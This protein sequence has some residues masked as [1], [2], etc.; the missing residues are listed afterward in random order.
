MDSVIFICLNFVLGTA[1]QSVNFKRSF[2]DQFIVSLWL[3]MVCTALERLLVQRGFNSRVCHMISLMI[4]NSAHAL[5][6]ISNVHD[7]TSQA[8][9]AA[10]IS[11]FGCGFYHHIGCRTSTFNLPA[12][13]LLSCNLILRYT[14]PSCTILST[15]RSIVHYMYNQPNDQM[16][17]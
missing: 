5:R 17:C 11:K 13:C 1:C 14:K 10:I 16:K 4:N 15:L 12:C 6:I 3:S 9:Q 7:L 8:E 2:S